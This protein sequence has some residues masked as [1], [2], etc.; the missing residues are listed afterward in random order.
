[1]LERG[2]LL[3]PVIA[4]SFC[5]PLLL[6]VITF[7]FLL[8]VH[9]WSVLKHPSLRLDLVI[10]FREGTNGI[11]FD[12]HAIVQLVV[13]HLAEFFTAHENVAI[14]ALVASRISSVLFHSSDA[15]LGIPG[16]L[17]TDLFGYLSQEW[18]E[19]G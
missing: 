12:A 16:L 13:E 3:F 4:H 2:V 7:I 6:I 11:V 15:S 18:M 14:E 9:V 5:L 19:H 1:M 10:N 8:A 17:L